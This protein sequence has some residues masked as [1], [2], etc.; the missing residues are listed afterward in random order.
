MKRAVAAGLGVSVLLACAARDE[1]AAGSLV[2]V[3][4]GPPALSRRIWAVLP[5]ATP[6]QAP[7]RLFLQRIGTAIAPLDPR[8]A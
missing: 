3:P 8:E 4:L 6:A 2:A 7:A 1:I 5:E